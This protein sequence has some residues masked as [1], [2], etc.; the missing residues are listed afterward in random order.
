VGAV[1]KPI[2]SLQGK[3]KSGRKND[4]GVA[5]GGPL[6]R[7][8]RSLKIHVALA[9]VEARPVVP[10]SRVGQWESLSASRHLRRIE[11]QA[12]DGAP[13]GQIH[14]QM[15]ASDRVSAR[16]RPAASP[17]RS[18]RDSSWTSLTRSEAKRAGASSSS[19][20]RP[21]QLAVLNSWKALTQQLDSGVAALVAR[22][23]S[24]APLAPQLPS[25]SLR[26]AGLD[27]TS[28]ATGKMSWL[29]LLPR[30]TQAGRAS[31]RGK[32]GA[33]HH[34]TKN[35]RASGLIAKVTSKRR[36]ILARDRGLSKGRFRKLPKELGRSGQPS[37][38]CQGKND[39]IQADGSGSCLSALRPAKLQEAWPWEPLSANNTASSGPS[40]R[41]KATKIP[42]LQ[43]QG[44]LLRNAAHGF[45][46]GSRARMSSALPRV[47]EITRCLAV[48]P[49]A[50]A[51]RLCHA[52]CDEFLEK[53][54]TSL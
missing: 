32:F 46:K 8:A 42:R 45:T 35:P 13:I 2:L 20:L 21:P 12:R 25:E 3:P 54:R 27:L 53:V 15:A 38:G 41:S 11:G 51:G 37:P 36:Q 4:D 34:S 29:P 44:P 5:T 47:G 33:G 17:R 19:A 30:P 16:N 28:C 43:G 9:I 31:R 7:M 50:P 48:R 52:Q 40:D 1:S 14:Q 10:S 26:R 24:K 23:D 49:V 18:L 22:G 39:W 6:G